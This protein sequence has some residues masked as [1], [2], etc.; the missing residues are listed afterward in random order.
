V[1][2]P[3]QDRSAPGHGGDR[4]GGGKKEAATG[5]VGSCRSSATS[6]LRENLPRCGGTTATGSH[7]RPI[8]RRVPR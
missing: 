5:A 4:R 6:K 7:A 8:A 3:G 1:V 2:G